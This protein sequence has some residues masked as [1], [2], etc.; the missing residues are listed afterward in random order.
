MGTGTISQSVSLG[1]IALPIMRRGVGRLATTGNRCLASVLLAVMTLWPQPASA[2]DRG[3]P[4]EFD[5]AEIPIALLVDAS[6]GQVLYTR[7]ANRRFVPASITKVMTLYTAFE[8]IDAGQFDTRRS[9][10]VAPEIWKK[11]R[12]KG[13]RMF[14]DA[15]DRVNVSDLLTGIANISANDASAV[16]ANELA[17]SGPRWAQLMNARA[18]TLG[19]RQSHFGTPNGWP[20][21]GYTFTTAMDL[22]KLGRALITDHPKKFARYIGKREFT[23]ND[24]TQA[25]HD[26]LLG[27]VSG[28]DG[29]KTG[30]T[31]ESGFGYLGTVKRGDHRL[32]IVIGGAR[33]ESLR[34][35]AARDLIEWGFSAFDR[36]PVF[37]AGGV[38]GS[39]RVQNGS[40]RSVPLVVD[41]QLTLNVPKGASKELSMSIVYDGPLRAPITAGERVAVLEVTAKGMP[42]SEIPLRAQHSVEK[43]GPFSRII[44]G[45][46]GWLS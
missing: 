10:R 28:A 31:N 45:I 3:N 14:L 39:A 44:N 32:M 24:I 22:V 5:E 27:R 41:G 37:A 16:I 1:F 34:R 43:A 29:I 42:T 35:Q 36:R 30:Y 46:T 38:V 17:G 18:R 15:G 6:S 12:G 20:D 21:E 19:M 9:I 33:R 13:S 11:W 25:N 2:A 40:S 8:M 4:P 26:P 23:Y 7:G